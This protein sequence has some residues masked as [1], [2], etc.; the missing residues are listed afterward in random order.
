MAKIQG[1]D[2]RID[3][4]QIAILDIESILNLII[5]GLENMKGLNFASP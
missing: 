5:L 2:E 3:K 1:S 4:S